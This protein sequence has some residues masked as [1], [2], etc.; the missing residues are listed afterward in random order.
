MI[1]HADFKV[2]QGFAELAWE[3]LRMRHYSQPQSFAADLERQ[4]FNGRPGAFDAELFYIAADLQ[5]LAKDAPPDKREA[6]ASIC[7]LLRA[8]ATSG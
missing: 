8:L 5:E 3:D 1:K 7:N 6:V 2:F 4:P